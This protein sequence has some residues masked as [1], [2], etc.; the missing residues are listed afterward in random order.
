MRD[1]PLAVSNPPLALSQLAKKERACS[2]TWTEHK[3]CRS[4]IVRIEA[5]SA[6]V[7]QG[8][9]TFT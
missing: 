6:Q 3:S 9:F 7:A 8:H 4:F 2:K 5:L 1:I